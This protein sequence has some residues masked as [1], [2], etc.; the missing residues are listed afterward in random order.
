MYSAVLSTGVLGCA[1]I[2]IHCAQFVTSTY[3]V[4]QEM[5]NSISISNKILL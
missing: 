3:C 1:K 4:M 5:I 2:L